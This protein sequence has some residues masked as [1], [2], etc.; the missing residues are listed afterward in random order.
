VSSVP[1]VEAQSERELAFHLVRFERLP[2]AATLEQAL[3]LMVRAVVDFQRQE[4][5]LM[6]RTLEALPH[7]GRCPKLVERAKR[8][9]EFLRALLETHREELAVDDLELAT[10]VV[11]NALHSLTHDGVLARPPWLDD[12][13]LVREALR[14]ALGYLGRG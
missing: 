3:E 2:A 9:T 7:L 1:L 4:G 8:A 11:A 14:L 5:P 10:H 13:R 12:E 6:R